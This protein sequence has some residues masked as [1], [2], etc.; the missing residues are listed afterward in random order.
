MK[1]N[2]ILKKNK[3]IG[4]F[5]YVH[6]YIN[7]L[8]KDTKEIEQVVGRKKLEAMFNIK[9]TEKTW[10]PSDPDL[11]KYCFDILMFPLTLNQ[12]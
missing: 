10:E 8:R 11:I 3:S 7:N 4:K 1:I 5:T 6:V 9:E 2:I 12:N